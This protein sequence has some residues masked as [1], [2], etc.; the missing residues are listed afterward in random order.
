MTDLIIIGVCWVLIV[1]AYRVGREHGRDIALLEFERE[2]AEERARRI[3][4]VSEIK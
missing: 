3:T 2:E 4:R 1:V